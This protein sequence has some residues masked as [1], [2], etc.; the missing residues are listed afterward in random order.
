MVAHYGFGTRLYAAKEQLEGRICTKKS[1]IYSL[2]VILVE[3]LLKCTTF[4]ECSNKIDSLKK[5]EALPEIEADICDLLYK[6]LQNRADLRPEINT[7][8]E[9]VSGLI[10]NSSNEV[11]RL[12][13]IIVEKDL[14]ID[15]LMEEIKSLK[16]Q[17]SK[18]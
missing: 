5:N 6:M 7:I 11:V 18:G 13:N 16:Q 12:K 4:M 14:R 3:L 10:E 8:K 9:K 15:E 17:L 1:D 2:A